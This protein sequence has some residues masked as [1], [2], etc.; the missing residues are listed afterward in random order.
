MPASSSLS[1]ASAFFVALAASS[2]L[3]RSLETRSVWQPAPGTSW[4]IQL[5]EEL[6]VD[7]NSPTLPN[8]VEVIDIDLFT[9]TGNTFTNP[10]DSK[11][12][13]LHAA[14]KKGSGLNG[15]PDETWLN[16]KSENVANIMRDRIALAAKVGCD[17]IDPDNMDGYDNENGIGLT[18]QDT[19]DYFKNVL[20]P[21][22]Q[23]HGL[24]LGLKNSINIIPD[25]LPVTQFVVTE[26]C[27]EY[28]ECD[29]YQPYITAGKPVFQIEYPMGESSSATK[30][31]AVDST[32]T[33]CAAQANGFSTVLKLL[34][35]NSW[36]QTCGGEVTVP[37]TTG[38]APSATTTAG[39][40]T[41][42]APTTTTKEAAVPTTTTSAAA[43][44]TATSDSGSDDDEEDDSGS[45]SDSGRGKGKGR[46]GRRNRKTY[47]RQ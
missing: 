36:V 37:T 25:V 22:A 38:Q 14:N 21:A 32:N 47:N 12:K 27:A 46:G 5:S 9:N 24:A 16:L 7:L 13:A 30:S 41:S 8:N 2:P 15:W 29:K 4:D 43:S 23:Q 28:S 44:A 17:G 11:I 19:I 26:Q 33:F 40:K 20:S 31:L 42:Q 34:S 45:D 3:R 1:L 35:L 39:S 6:K 10:D 18:K